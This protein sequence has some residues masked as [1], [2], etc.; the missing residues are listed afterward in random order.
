MRKHN[1]YNKKKSNLRRDNYNSNYNYY[2]FFCHN[3]RNKR[4][5]FTDYSSDYNNSD[6]NGFYSDHYYSDFSGQIYTNTSFNKKSNQSKNINDIDNNKNWILKSEKD[7]DIYE[8]NKLYLEFNLDS[9]AKEDYLLEDLNIKKCGDKYEEC[10]I[11]FINKILKDKCIRNNKNSIISF[12]ENEIKETLTINPDG[13]LVKLNKDDLKNILD[14]KHIFFGKNIEIN[15]LTDEINGIVEISLSIKRKFDQYQNYIDFIKIF[16]YNIDIKDGSKKLLEINNGYL[17]NLSTKNKLILMIILNNDY[18]DFINTKELF[19]KENAEF[20]KNS[21][22]SILRMLY[23][24]E[25]PIIIGYLPKLYLNET[26]LNFVKFRKIN[27]KL[28]ENDEETKEKKEITKDFENNI[29]NIKENEERNEEDSLSYLFDLPKA[30]ENDYLIKRM[31]YIKDMFSKQIN[32][33]KELEEKITIEKGKVNQKDKQNKANE[34][35]I[36]N[37][38]QK[39]MEQNK[40]KEEKIKNLEQKIMEQ[41]KANEEKIKKQKKMEQN[42]ANEEKIKN[43]E[44]KIMEQNKANEEK[45]NEIENQKLKKEIQLETKIY[46]LKM[47]LEDK[48]NKLKKL[49][50]NNQIINS[51]RFK[52]DEEQK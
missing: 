52:S 3:N 19:L 15:N 40:A 32:K 27:R 5:A 2:P 21:I 49:S 16:N 14:K 47:K 42:K 35:K 9:M 29:I 45:I 10:S 26:F 13:Y 22:G 12:Q 23:Y 6:N 37:L 31:N 39:I 11:K 24:C 1:F 48:T 30:L 51:K 38:E 33:Q 20:P 34:E 46:E 28:I 25:I 36:K 4:T 17:P 41:N 44:Q 50:E 18:S 7:K 8:R 43:L